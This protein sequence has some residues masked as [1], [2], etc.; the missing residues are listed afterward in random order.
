MKTHITYSFIHIEFVA[1]V[2][3]SSKL[4]VAVLIVLFANY[5][6]IVK[7]TSMK[8]I[9]PLIV[10]CV[11]LIFS[12]SEINGK[13]IIDSA[14]DDRLNELGTRRFIFR[15]FLSLLRVLQ[16]ISELEIKFNSIFR[17]EN[18]PK[19]CKYVWLSTEKRHKRRRFYKWVTT[20]LR[21]CNTSWCLYSGQ[22]RC[23][24]YFSANWWIW[25]FGA[26]VRNW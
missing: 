16:R 13:N 25:S 22:S 19:I 12:C 26:I 5:V 24:H 1:F 6:K 17:A 3:S 10:F 9:N 7:I 15:F 14:S 20:G 4:C 21:R 8:M 18:L 2:N 23:A 11:H